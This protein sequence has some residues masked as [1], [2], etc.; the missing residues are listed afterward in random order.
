MA[1]GATFPSWLAVDGCLAKPGAA[2]APFRPVTRY[3]T[4]SQPSTLM[5]A[6][7]LTVVWR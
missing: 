5:A 4:P 2:H 7:S 6:A 3:E 1:S